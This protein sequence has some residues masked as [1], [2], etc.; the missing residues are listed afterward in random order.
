MNPDIPSPTR[1]SEEPYYVKAVTVKDQTSTELLEIV[2]LLQEQLG[3]LD[4]AIV[5]WQHLSVLKPDHPAAT[6]RLVRLYMLRTSYK[7]ALPL[8]QK[9]HEQ[10]PDEACYA[11]MLGRVYLQERLIEP[12]EVAFTAARQ[13]DSEDREIVLNLGALY[14]YR[15]KQ[16]EAAKL[17]KDYLIYDDRDREI[18]RLFVAQQIR[19]KRVDTDTVA[20][21]ELEARD[22]PSAGN[23]YRLAMAYRLKGGEDLSQLTLEKA[24]AVDPAHDKTLTALGKHYF[25]KSDYA[26]AKDYF[27]RVSQEG[28]ESDDA[29]EFL[30]KIRLLTTPVAKKAVKKNSAATKINKKSGQLSVKK[31]SG[32]PVKQT[33][34]A[35][36]GENR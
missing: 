32:K 9:L 12:A 17:Y 20:M 23:L 1:N 11:A 36:T 15:G 25:L 5:S 7:Q 2:A 18:R 6:D 22:E 34:P 10:Q 16:E 31:R 26:K 24:L 3:R 29:D 21:L 14:R 8:L 19:L 27:T 35:K 4:E 33:K 13:A 30:R 28:N